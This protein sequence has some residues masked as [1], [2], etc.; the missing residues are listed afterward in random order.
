MKRTRDG[1]AMLEVLLALV[2]LVMVLVPTVSA[3]CASH[4]HTVRAEDLARFQ[5]L[6]RSLMDAAARCDFLQLTRDASTKDADSAPWLAWQE[7]VVGHPSKDL[8]VRSW[9]E[10]IDQEADAVLFVV[11]VRWSDPKSKGRKTAYATRVERLLVRPEASLSMI[12]EVR[13]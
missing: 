9:I 8:S 10:K 5:G 6:A 1:I 12:V 2:M 3:M 13:K 11:E 7:S 4:H